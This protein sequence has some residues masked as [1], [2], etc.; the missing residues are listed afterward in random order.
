MLV[1]TSTRC[2]AVLRSCELYL[3]HLMSQK[4]DGGHSVAAFS[5][6]EVSTADEDDSVENIPPPPKRRKTAGSI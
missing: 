2:H 3:D 5:M 4:D 1:N 6:T